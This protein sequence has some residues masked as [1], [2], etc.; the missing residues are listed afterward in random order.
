ML[1]VLSVP[2]VKRISYSEVELTLC[3][4]D[5][6]AANLLGIMIYWNRVKVRSNPQVL[7]ENERRAKDGLD[8]I[9]VDRWV[10]KTYEGFVDDSMGNLKRH[11]VKR[12]LKLLLERGF[13]EDRNNP[14]F[15][16]D[17][18]KQYRL[19]VDAVNA[20]TRSAFGDLLNGH[21]QPIDRSQVTDG[22][23]TG[24]LAIPEITNTEITT[25]N[26]SLGENPSDPPVTEEEEEGKY[27]H[28]SFE[29]KVS[30]RVYELLKAR[31][32]LALY[33]RN[34][35][36]KK[37][38]AELQKWAH[39]VN[40]MKRLD[41]LPEKTIIDFFKWLFE[42]DD[43][44]VSE[45][46]FQSMNGLRKPTSKSGQRKLDSMM[47]KFERSR[48]GPKVKMPNQGEKVP[49]VWYLRILQAHPELAP[50]FK[51]TVND[52]NN[53]PQYFYRPDLAGVTS[54]AA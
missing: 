22:E 31:N 9:E 18:T 45:G 10:Y 17:R 30:R 23:V 8:S 35:S 4:G 11:D 13:I 52:E 50:A 32:A 6:A 2:G 53:K 25:S 42:E 40:Q 1:E 14:R 49:E 19:N 12:G 16:W 33:L 47:S 24:D 39:V 21:G 43:W 37:L 34:K 38:E 29:Y 26:N 51:R 36:G 46:N 28:E 7:A 3:D 5:H 27:S 48:T 44:W 41:G 15:Q 20:A 54:Q